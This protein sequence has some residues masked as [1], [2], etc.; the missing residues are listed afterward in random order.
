[1]ATATIARLAVSLDV[2]SQK[3]SQKL[4]DAEKNTKKFSSGASKA[5]RAINNPVTVAIGSFTALA[6]ATIKV[7]R[8]ASE[9]DRMAKRM[10]AT[11]SAY[12]ALDIAAKQYGSSGEQLSDITKDIT[13]K[14]RE[15]AR[16]GTGAFQDVATELGLSSDEAKTFA[17]QLTN[18][19]GEDQLKAIVSQLE[20]AGLSGQE[21]TQALESMGNDLSVL[22]PLLANNGA[23]LDRIQN[24]FY[25]VNNQL[26]DEQRAKY[27]KFNEALDLLGGT[28]QNTL[29]QSFAGLAG[30]AAEAA[31]EISRML[32]LLQGAKAAKAQDEIDVIDQS[33]ADIQEKIAKVNDEHENGVFGFKTS[34]EYAEGQLKIYNDQLKALRLQRGMQEDIVQAE[35]NKNKASTGNRSINVSVS[36]SVS[37]GA[38]SAA[39]KAA[40]KLKADQDAKQAKKLDDLRA[41]Q[42]Y[43]EEQQAQL[44][45]KTLE[46]SF[47][48]EDELREAHYEDQLDKLNVWLDKDLI[49]REKYKDLRNQLNEQW[50][51]DEQ[52]S[53]EM[54]G[55][56][57]ANAADALFQ[58]NKASA[59]R[60][61]ILAMQEN[62]AQAS[63]LGFPMNLAAIAGAIAQGTNIVNTIKGIAHDGLDNVPEEGTYLLQKGETVL[64]KQDAQDYRSGNMKG[65][66]TQNISI[67][68]TIN[69][70]GRDSE[71]D[72]QLMN[73][74]QMMILN[75]IKSNGKIGRAI[76]SYQ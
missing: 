43:A 34:K 8:Q 48:T 16:D 58:T 64:K 39:Q 45:I 37:G 1:M 61:A 54:L 38:S 32:G 56:S 2:N 57:A 12:Q 25:G 51:K 35:L 17:N 26:S 31:N 75:D 68:P 42:R 27:K 7:T 22:Y 65:S 30:L 24:A 72:N 21:M 40:D 52:S 73:R 20:A 23:E 19:S 4:K 14:V 5:F 41:K 62:I 29:Y 44:Q 10:G 46:E 6:A 53:N 47:M 18:L 11:T 63:T 36:T 9:L 69:S 28:I 3:F 13:D 67:N 76:R 33:M 50:V 15:F 49:T 74:M 70:S 71:S 66:N 59:L 60:S 55:E